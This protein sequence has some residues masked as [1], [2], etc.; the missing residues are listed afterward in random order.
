M[1]YSNSVA[2]HDRFDPPLHL[3]RRGLVLKRKLK[4]SISSRN[5]IGA[6]V[7]VVQVVTLPTVGRGERRGRCLQSPRV[8]PFGHCAGAST[9]RV[10]RAMR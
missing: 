9:C 7:S 6:P 4:S 5:H 2:L 10:L 1:R 3:F 8:G